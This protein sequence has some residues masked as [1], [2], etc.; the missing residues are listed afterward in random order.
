MATSSTPSW[1][2]IL[3]FLVGWTSLVNA[4]PVIAPPYPSNKTRTNFCPVMAKYTT[5]K[6]TIQNALTG[7]TVYVGVEPASPPFY[8]VVNQTTGKPSKGFSVALLAAMAT[9]GGFTVK[10]VP[11]PN[12]PSNGSS[13]L[14]WLQRV[15]SN[16]DLVADSA[17]YD[18]PA[19]R[20]QGDGGPFS[21]R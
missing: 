19:L 1:R 10:Y 16:V 4:A 9:T 7:M 15:V 18:T 2:F 14:P 8:M 21:R 20:A 6:A 3:L 17:F 5:G 13:L 12:R 11:I